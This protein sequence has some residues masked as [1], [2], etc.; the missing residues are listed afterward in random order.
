MRTAKLVAAVAAVGA[1]VLPVPAGAAGI[2]PLAA[3][4]SAQALRVTY[5]MPGSGAVGTLL[6]GGGPVSEATGDSN[7]RAVTFASL[8]YPGETALFL[9]GVL[10]AAAGLPAPAGYPFYAR[11][12][13]PTAPQSEV[14][15]PS[16][17]YVLRARADRGR[18]DG[19]AAIQFIG[20]GADAVSRSSSAT[21]FTLDDRGDATVVAETQT[22]GISLGGGAL[23]IASV[24]SRSTSTYLQGNDRPVVSRELVI[25]GARALRQSVSIQPDGVHVDDK[26]AQGPFRD[27]SQLL[28]DALRQSGITVRTVSGDGSGS[29]DV[30]EITSHQPVP[31]PGNPK[32]TLVWRSGAVTTG[33]NLG[34]PGDSH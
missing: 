6:D 32:G 31:L 11:A 29:A 4:A 26:F 24:R 34:P 2:R 25:E 1:A 27:G 3:T 15:D 21:H 20:E 10:A 28:N 13:Y 9:P 16:G 30:L 14:V 22:W 7:G 12:D 8:P 18:A 23:T 17:T 33:I 19:E 5:T